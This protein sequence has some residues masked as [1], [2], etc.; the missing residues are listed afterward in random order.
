MGSTLRRKLKAGDKL[1]AANEFPKWCRANGKEV[2]GI[3]RRRKAESAMI[4]K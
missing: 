4:L 2:D 1:G 3:K